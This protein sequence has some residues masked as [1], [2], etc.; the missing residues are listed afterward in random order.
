MPIAPPKPDFLE[1]NPELTAPDVAA[2]I[3]IPKAKPPTPAKP[4]IAVD[5]PDRI[6]AKPTPPAKSPLLLAKTDF[7]PSPNSTPVPSPSIEKSGFSLDAQSGIAKSP[8]IAVSDPP[9]VER[10]VQPPALGWLARKNTSARASSGRYNPKAQQ[11][12]KTNEHSSL[13]S[14][15]YMQ[16]RLPPRPIVED[17]E[18]ESEVKPKSLGPAP[19]VPNHKVR[20]D[21]VSDTGI[22]KVSYGSIPNHANQLNEFFKEPELPTIKL[23]LDMTQ[24]LPSRTPEYEKVK[25]VKLDVWEVS[26]DGK[27]QTVPAGNEHILFDENMYM[28]LHI[29]ERNSGQKDAEFFLWSGSQVSPATVED[30]QIF[31]KKMANENEASMVRNAISIES[32][33]CGLTLPSLWCNK[34]MKLLLS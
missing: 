8:S 23:N 5:E 34:G 19:I 31:A 7:K 16:P 22:R 11:E 9:P 15:T 21:L 4:S 3:E 13:A 29:F 30:A 25:T 26:V 27:V 28:C 2:E 17:E 12:G 14:N 6:K 24:F 20:V 18:D 10:P 32:V 1:Q 33:N